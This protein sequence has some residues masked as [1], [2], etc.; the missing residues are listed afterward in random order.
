ME[1]E[2]IIKNAISTEKVVRLMEKENKLAFIV[3][4]KANKNEIKNAVEKLFNVKVDNVRT[5]LTIKGE[6]KAIVKLNKEFKAIDVAT[7]LKLI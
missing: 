3:D 2:E 1:P 6:K 4:K 7:K 5:M